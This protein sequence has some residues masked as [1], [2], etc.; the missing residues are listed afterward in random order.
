MDSARMVSGFS[1]HTGN[2]RD[3]EA[4]TL[5]MDPFR[6]TLRPRFPAVLPGWTKAKAEA[7]SSSLEVSGLPIVR[8]RTPRASRSGRSRGV[9]SFQV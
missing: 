3:N 2:R 9:L 1:R 5:R 7:G 4:L 8:P 6:N